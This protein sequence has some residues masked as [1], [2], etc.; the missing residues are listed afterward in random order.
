VTISGSALSDDAVNS[1]ADQ[2]YD[3]VAPLL[4]QSLNSPNLNVELTVVD[5][6]RRKASAFLLLLC[7]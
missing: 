3:S 5:G 4:N 1:I 6:M 2:I 7:T